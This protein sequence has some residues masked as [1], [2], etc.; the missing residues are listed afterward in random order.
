M[1]IGNAISGGKVELASKSVILFDEHSDIEFQLDFAPQFIGRRTLRFEFKEDKEKNNG[2]SFLE[3]KSE[4]DIIVLELYNIENPFGIGL[5]QP[6]PILESSGRFI[7]ILFDVR[8]P[9][10]NMPRVLT[11]TLYADR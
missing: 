8:R 9:E 10:K 3:M 5:K 6:K 7:Y 1:E 11:F 2:D 4:N